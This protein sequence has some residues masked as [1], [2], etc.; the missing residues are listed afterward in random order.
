MSK[1][2][3]REKRKYAPD[4]DI[5]HIWYGLKHRTLVQC[6]CTF[7]TQRHSMGQ[8]RARLAKGREYIHHTSDFGWTERCRNGWMDRLITIMC[9]QSV[10]L[11]IPNQVSQK[12]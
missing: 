1:I 5:L 4:K 11:L 10:A 3:P 12:L 6:Y 8:V 9:L 2:G 7:F